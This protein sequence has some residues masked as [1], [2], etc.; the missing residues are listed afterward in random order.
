M[1]L[2]FALMLAAGI[3]MAMIQDRHEPIPAYLLIACISGL[4]GCVFCALYA[5]TKAPA[6]LVPGKVD[7]K[8]LRIKF[9]NGTYADLFLELNKPNA[10]VI[11][12]W[13]FE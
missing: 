4:F 9:L 1:G 11:N 7:N 6:R 8:N 12:P 13:K 3:P 2:C 5:K 10:C